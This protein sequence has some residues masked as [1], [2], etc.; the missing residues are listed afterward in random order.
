ML[1][2]AKKSARPEHICSLRFFKTMPNIT[3]FL[4]DETACEFSTTDHSHAYK[5]LFVKSS[6]PT[7]KLVCGCVC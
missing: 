4:E 7:Q 2:K 3:A 1:I 5:T 6:Y